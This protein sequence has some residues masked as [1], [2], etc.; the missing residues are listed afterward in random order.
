LSYIYDED[1][2]EETIDT[3][4]TEEEAH[5]YEYDEDSKKKKKYYDTGVFDLFPELNYIRNQDLMY[6]INMSKLTYAYFTSFQYR[7]H[8]IILGHVDEINDETIEMAKKGRAKRLQF[9]QARK[10]ITDKEKNYV[11]VNKKVPLEDYSDY[12][13]EDLV[14]RVMTYEHIPENPKPPKV[15]RRESDNHI[16]LNYHPFKHYAFIDGKITEV[17]RSHWKGDLETGCFS[18]DHGKMTDGLAVLIVNLIRRY[19]CQFSWQKLTYL[20]ELQEDAIV[21]MMS[22]CL[23]FN[24][25]KSDKAFSFMTQCVKNSFRGTLKDER[26]LRDL[27]DEMNQ[28]H[29]PN[30]QVSYSKQVEFDLANKEAKVVAESLIDSEEFDKDFQEY[31]TNN[32]HRYTGFTEVEVSTMIKEHIKDISGVNNEETV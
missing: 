1:I 18:K 23:K 25:Y 11:K 31:Y 19:S 20:A 28:I 5:I 24:E 29:D 27:K 15:I 10:L 21:H 12:K 22:A 3:E 26:N 2:E 8:D 7:K 13:I 9:E 6:E 14:F 17:G 4:E 16:R 32:R 30:M